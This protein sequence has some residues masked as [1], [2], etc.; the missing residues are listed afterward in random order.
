MLRITRH[1]YRRDKPDAVDMAVIHLIWVNLGVSRYADG[2]WVFSITT[3]RRY[4]GI[5]VTI[6]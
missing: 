4:Y 1:Q 3:P 5:T 2:D 6:N